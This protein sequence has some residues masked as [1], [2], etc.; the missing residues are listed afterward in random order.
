MRVSLKQTVG[1]R[2]RHARACSHAAPV[3]LALWV[4]ALVI[5]LPGGITAQVSAGRGLILTIRELAR[6][7]ELVVVG[8]VVDTRGEW[9]GTRRTIIT[10]IDFRV[11]EV[12]K[13]DAGPGVLQLVQPGGQV[14]DVVAA[15]GDAPSFDVGERALLFLSRRPDG[16]LRV[17][18]LYMGKFTLEHDVAVGVTV[19]VRRL[20]GSGEVLDRIPLDE[21]R[22]IVGGAA[23]P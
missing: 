2:R 21:I 17:A 5:V 6:N 7:A 10:R 19:A 8:E 13:G 4:L 11:D 15:V 14:G 16:L 23:R 9:N 3:S 1:A 22:R 20:P 12:L 18:H